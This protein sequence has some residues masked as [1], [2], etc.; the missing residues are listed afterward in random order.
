MVKIFLDSDS[1]IQISH[2]PQ[3]KGIYRF[4]QDTIISLSKELC[5]MLNWK[6]IGMIPDTFLVL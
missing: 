3:L 4:D 2:S 1:M 5:K 6:D